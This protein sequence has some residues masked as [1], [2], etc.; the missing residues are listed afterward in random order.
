MRISQSS[1]GIDDDLVT[2][3]KVRTMTSSRTAV[4][5]LTPKATGR[6]VR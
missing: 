3:D 5:V 4:E 2:E 1:D 6:R